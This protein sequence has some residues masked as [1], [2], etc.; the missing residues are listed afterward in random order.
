VREF[1]SRAAARQTREPRK[2]AKG[3]YIGPPA[4][5][6]LELACR[7]INEAFCEDGFGC[8]VVGSALKRRDWRDIDIVCILS[9]EVFD[10]LF[11]TAGDG[12]CEFDPRWLIMTISISKWLAERCGYPVDFKFQRQSHANKFHRGPRNAIGLK[13][14]KKA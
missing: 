12:L 1:S 2:R 5:F 8:Y 10:S 3:V 7:Q 11:P 4:C 9:D 14:A 13:I 6:E